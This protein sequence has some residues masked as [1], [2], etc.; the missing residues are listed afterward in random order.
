M[1]YLETSELQERV[2]VLNQW[3]SVNDETHF[4]Y[5]TVLIERNVYSDEFDKLDETGA[6]MAEIKVYTNCYGLI[7]HKML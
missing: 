1:E 3:L 6:P 4:Q 2:L 7:K 5:R